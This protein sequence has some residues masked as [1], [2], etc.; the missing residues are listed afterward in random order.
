M[1]Q[2]PHLVLGLAVILGGSAPATAQEPIAQQLLH[3]AVGILA[4]PEFEAQ[5]RFASTK[6]NGQVRTFSIHMWKKG[7]TL[8]RFRFLAPEDDRDMEVLRR[9]DDMW[10]YMPSLKRAVR[11]SPKQEFHGG[12]FSN[13]DVLRVDLEQDYTPTLQAAAQPDQA[14]LDL[15]A[16]NDQVAYHR[17]RFWLRKKDAMP[18]REE[19]YAASGKLVRTCEFLDVKTFGHLVRPSRYVM[20]NMLVPSRSTEMVWESLQSQRIEEATMFEVATLGKQSS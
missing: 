18:L 6:A 7:S 11:I 9:S 17:V 20:R 2:R 10:N 14:V 19:F 1:I 3:R 5:V 13:S 8:T 12:D 16:K 4:P 15:V